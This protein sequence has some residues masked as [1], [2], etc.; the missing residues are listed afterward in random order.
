MPLQR[1]KMSV[2]LAELQIS[3]R[4]S[5]KVYPSCLCIYWYFLIYL[6]LENDREGLPQPKH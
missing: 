3:L 4:T 6:Q 1:D 5:V 2:D